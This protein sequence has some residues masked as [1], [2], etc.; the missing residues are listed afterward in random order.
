MTEVDFYILQSAQPNDRAV[1]ACRLADKAFRRGHGVYINTCDETS[2]GEINELLWSFRQQSF[3][4]HGI[5]GQDHSDRI[6]IGWGDDPGEHH[7][8][9]INLDLSVPAFVGR[10]EHVAEVV[11]QDPGIR[12]PLRHSWKYFKDRGYPI[13][14][15]NL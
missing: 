14:N 2:A 3:T 13:K 9:M 8:F 6:A 12:D 1:F 15:N 10:F 5:L 7:D 4:P 11:V